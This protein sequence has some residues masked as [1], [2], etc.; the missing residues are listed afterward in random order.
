MT[1]PCCQALQEAFQL[2]ALVLLYFS[3]RDA[4]AVPKRLK[5]GRKWKRSRR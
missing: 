3:R 4:R 1:D 5:A 2:A